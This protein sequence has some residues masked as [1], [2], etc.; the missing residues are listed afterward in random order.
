MQ[1][2]S[3]ENRMNRVN[4]AINDWLDK[5]P[6][7][8]NACFIM[9]TYAT[10]NKMVKQK[11]DGYI[12]FVGSK[13]LNHVTHV[14]GI[15]NNVKIDPFA[16]K[17]LSD[18]QI[19]EIDSLDFFKKVRIPYT[20]VTTA[21]ISNIMD[22]I[23]IKLVNGEK[24]RK[25]HIEFTMGGHGYVYDWVKENKIII[26]NKMSENDIICTILHELIERTL[27]KFK[28]YSYNKAH[29]IANIIEKT[30]RIIIEREEK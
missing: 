13:K 17:Y 14:Y 23:K 8:S 9:N 16:I 29:K 5:K 4:Q 25:K 12:V 26:D 27:M 6:M 19:K 24:I 11:T 18:N 7:V 15:I 10:L 22:E 20:E 30:L 2:F 28:N 21:S 1:P 3:L